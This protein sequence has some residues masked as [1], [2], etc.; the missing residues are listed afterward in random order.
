MTLAILMEL[1]QYGTLYDVMS[2]ARR[3]MHINQDIRMGR[4]PPNYLQNNELKVCLIQVHLPMRPLVL[5]L[6]T[7]PVLLK[8]SRP[9]AWRVLKILSC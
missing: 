9:F 6:T 8:G 3:I 1:C 2:Q 7:V 4:L 5:C